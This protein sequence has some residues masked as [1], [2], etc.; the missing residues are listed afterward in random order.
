MNAG[1]REKLDKFRK[2]VLSCQT[3]EQLL[4]IRDW[5][6]R[7][8]FENEGYLTL[9]KQTLLSKENSLISKAQVKEQTAGRS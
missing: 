8:T 7:L 2:V 1:D 3:Y 9:C 5:I 6:N 4:F